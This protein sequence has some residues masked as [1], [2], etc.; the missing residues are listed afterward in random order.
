MIEYHPNTPKEG[1]PITYAC[2]YENGNVI[3]HLEQEVDGYYYFWPI[4][5]GGFWA[6]ETMADIAHKL[7]AL[8]EAWDQ[9]LQKALGDKPAPTFTD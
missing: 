1:Q 8:N 4:Y 9:K 6:S 2:I 5:K 7:D 3:G